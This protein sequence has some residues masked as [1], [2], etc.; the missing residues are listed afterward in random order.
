MA[1]ETLFDPPFE[2]LEPERAA[3]PFVFNSPHSGTIYPPLFVRASKLDFMTLRR[4]EDSFVDELFEP[5]VRLGA[6]LMRAH[7]PRA[8]VDVNREPYELDPKMFAQPLPPFANTRSLRVAGGLGTIARVVADAHEI[9][10]RPLSV[11]EGLARID[12][13]YKPYHAALAALVEQVRSTFGVCILVDCHSMPSSGRVGEIES[14]PDFVLGDR[15]GTSCLPALTDWI[16]ES[17]RGFGYLVG[18]NKPY[19]GGYI[20]EHYGDPARGVHAVQI[21]IN[22]ALYMD[23]ARYARTRGFTRL[24]GN[25]EHLFDQMRSLPWASFLATRAAA[26]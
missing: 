1:F 24:A 25:L 3:T 7:F 23:E 6:P 9:Y 5:V 14:R 26:E 8:Y 19:A 13:L 17:L 4:S 22:R 16:Q 20:T 18:R 21:E 12:R 10:A 11:E 2:I 15:Y